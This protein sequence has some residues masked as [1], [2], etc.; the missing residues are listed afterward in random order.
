MSFELSLNVEGMETVNHILHYCKELGSKPGGANLVA[1]GRDQSGVT[2]GQLLKYHAHLE[3]SN[4]TFPKR[5]YITNSAADN[6]KIGEAYAKTWDAEIQKHI[7]RK[8]KYEKQRARIAAGKKY[9]RPLKPPRDKKHM[10]NMW[11][12][13]MHKAGMK[14]YMGQVHDRLK[15]KHSNTGSIPELSPKYAEQKRKQ[16]GFTDPILVKTAQILDALDFGGLGGKNIRVTK[17]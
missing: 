10:A 15:T 2:S 9:K 5:D 3:G 11:R 17:D 6:E 1:P 4:W 12:A 8:L 14:I 13:K 16:V 7:N